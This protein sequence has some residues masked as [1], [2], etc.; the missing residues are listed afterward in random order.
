[1]PFV[2]GELRTAFQGRLTI[3]DHGDPASMEPIPK[4]TRA[5]D[6]AAIVRTVTRLSPGDLATVVAFIEGAA[7]QVGRHGSVAE[8]AAELIRWV[9]SPTGPG[10]EAI[11]SALENFLWA[12]RRAL[13]RS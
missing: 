10:L 3:R 6:R 5:P 11:Q 12:Q 13:C 9:E 4:E 2:T 1:M 7:P 8:Q